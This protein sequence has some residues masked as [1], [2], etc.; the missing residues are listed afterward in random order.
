MLTSFLSK[1]TRAKIA[2]AG[3]G[4]KMTEENKIKLRIRLQGNKYGLGI[5]RSV[6]TRK[7]MSAAKKG[8]KRQPF[9]E[10][11]RRKLGDSLSG[12]HHSEA[13]KKKMSTAQKGK[14]GSNWQGG[15]STISNR[16]RSSAKYKAWR[17]AI[18]ERD[19]YTCQ[20][21]GCGKTRRISKC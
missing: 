2:A 14:R 11:H 6:K 13:T 16:I 1:T 15:K 9:S 18:F 19:N 3:R 12:K 4:R 7:R 10:E 21:P 17:K 5:T 20:W 8:K